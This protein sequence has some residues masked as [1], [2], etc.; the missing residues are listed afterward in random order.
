MNKDKKIKHITINIDSYRYN[1]LKMIASKQRMNITQ[2]T[3]YLIIDNLQALYDS[4][5]TSDAIIKDI[6]DDPDNNVFIKK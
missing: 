3:Y 5:F 1:Q 2:A 6:K 4:W